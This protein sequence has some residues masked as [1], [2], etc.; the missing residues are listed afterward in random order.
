MLSKVVEKLFS[1]DYRLSIDSALRCIIFFLLLSIVYSP[2]SAQNVLTGEY[3]FDTDPGIGN[4]TTITFTAGANVTFTTSIPTTSLAVGFHQLAIRVKETGGRWS[5]FESRGFYITNALTDVSNISAAE[6]FFDTDPGQ[7]NATAIAI[8]AGATTNFTVSIPT[9]SLS[10]GFHFLAIRT[11]GANGKWGIFEARGFYVTSSTTDSPN[12]TGAEYFFDSDPGNG[13]GIPIAVSSGATVNFTVSLSIGLSPGFH[14]LAIRTK[15]ANGKWGVFE[16]R[17]FYVTGS[18]LDVPN[19]TKAEYFF[20]TDPGAGNGINIPITAGA[21]PNFTVSIPTTGLI[22]GFHFLA[23]RTKRADGNWGI[24]ESR[25]FYVSPI[26][27]NSSDI[28]AAEYFI[29]DVDPGEGNGL[30]LTVLTPGPTVNQSFIIVLNGIPS[31]VRKLN[32]RVEDAKG[33]WSP[34]ETASFNVLV[35]TPPSPPTATGASRCNNGT[36]TLNATTGVIGTQVYRWYADATNSTV[37]FTAAQFITPTISATTDYYVTVYDPATLCESNRIKVTASVISTTPPQLNITGSVTIC[38]G[39]AIKIS[40]PVGFTS[41]LWSNGEATR[42]ITVSIAGDYTVVVSNSTCTS[43]PSAPATVIISP[44]PAKPTVTTSGTVDLCDGASV[45]LTAP[46][47]FSYLWSSGQTT[48]AITVNTA[49]N[50]SVT[51]ADGSNCSSAPSNIIEVKTFVRPAKPTVDVIGTTTLCGTN[52]V[53]LLAPVGYTIYQWSGG[54]TTPGI[55]IAAAGNYSV[56]V[57]N[58]ANCLSIASEVVTVTN[59]G[60]ACTGGGTSNSPPAISSEP[61]ATQIEGKIEVDLTTLVNDSDNNID[62]ASLK[63]I[64]GT[65]SRGIAAFITSSFF[66]QINYSGS[67]FTGTDRIAIEVCDLAGACTQQVIDIEV[68]GEVIVFNGLSPD[69]DGLNDF[70]EIKYI[71]VVEGA[72]KNK[73]S[74]YNRWGDLVFE[75]DDY[76]NVS[77]V[78]TGVSNNGKELP[79]G[80]YFYKID[81][82]QGQPL[83]GFIILKR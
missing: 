70:M 78:F 58:T 53:G 20:D 21:S 55:N 38:E 32:L 14:F 22:S 64:N 60:Q 25:G 18:T 13:N 69:G 12:I 72:S 83:S 3:F 40:A 37:L 68:V 28:V 82:S 8:T 4:G 45:T 66:L 10:P 19:I 81:F 2:V 47:G 71:D 50:Y 39:N 11:K 9:I 35:C 15:G 52:T 54:Q 73:V 46:A 63:V 56:I 76:D 48:Q 5:E 74:I 36:V 42:E 24:F 29:D 61:F 6:Y 51:V 79:A 59:T 16:A 49:S 7:G 34:I 43:Q 1:L 31:G 65:T 23:I 30:P 67:P 75:T 62:F 33:I 17:G 41:Y 44:K 77:R 57:G 80:T 26:A 27:E